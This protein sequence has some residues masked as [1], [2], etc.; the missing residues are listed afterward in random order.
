MRIT[1]LAAPRCEGG[2]NPM[3][4]AS[5]QR[6]FYIDNIGQKVH[7]FDPASGLTETWATPSLVT[8]LVLREGGG[9]VV[10]L[11]SG[12]H[13]LDLTNGELELAVPLA[14]PPAI[15]FNDGKADSHGRFVIGAGAARNF[16]DPEPNGGLFS[17]STDQ[18]LSQIDS[19]IHLSNGPCW[20]PN[21]KTLY[22]SDSWLR[23]VYA[24]DYDVDTGQ[25]GG[26][27]VFATTGDLDGRPDGATVDADGLYWVAVYQGRKIAAFRP[28]GR[29]ERTIDM[30]V[31]VVSSV[32]FG[33]PQLDRL[34]VTT[35]AHGTGDDAA[36]YVYVIDG[37]GVR[38]LAEHRYAG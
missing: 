27:R 37:L 21:G 17:L 22:F 20:A 36:G 16:A 7:S 18:T 5:S 30:P 14:D 2:E 32:A 34:F 33:G 35:I 1:R 28:D 6:L 13:F 9:A 25:V 4:D 24:Y 38:G 12:V 10:T 23:T 15:I 29:L 26:R 19:G 31:D 8:T 11:R 3:W